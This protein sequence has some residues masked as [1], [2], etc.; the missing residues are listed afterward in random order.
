MKTPV[1]DPGNLILCE[2]SCK[3]SCDVQKVDALDVKDD[4]SNDDSDKDSEGN[5]REKK[6]CKFVAE[7]KR[8]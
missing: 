3:A 7:E 2:E 6:Y 8:N 1:I 5:Y 4:G